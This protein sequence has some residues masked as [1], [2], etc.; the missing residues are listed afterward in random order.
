MTTKTKTTQVIILAT[1]MLLSTAVIGFSITPDAEA[2]VKYYN[3]IDCPPGGM[4][5]HGTNGDDLIRGT[6][7]VDYIHGHGGNDRIFG[8][9]GNDRIY[10]GSG[11]DFIDGGSGKDTLKG[12]RGNDIIEGG[13]GNDTIYGASGKDTLKGESGDDTIYGHRGND[14][15]VGGPGADTLYG[16]SGVDTITAGTGH[17]PTDGAIDKIECDK[18]ERDD[19]RYSN[20][21]V[22][23]SHIQDT[24]KYCDNDQL[25]T[26]EDP[27]RT[28]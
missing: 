19:K 4:H 10:A 25:N 9:G 14:I 8:Y 15:I 18:N 23:R 22:Y 2:G 11:N 17:H 12:D 28:R 26:D 16:G 6:P 5:C 21:I 27:V 24:T 13:A 20:N 3:E 7:G 1:V